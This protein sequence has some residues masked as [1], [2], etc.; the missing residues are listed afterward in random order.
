MFL[1]TVILS[2]LEPSMLVKEQSDVF[3]KCFLA[4]SAGSS[5]L[6]LFI[7]SIVEPVLTMERDF[8][9]ENSGHN[10]EFWQQLAVGVKI[11]CVSGFIA[12]HNSGVFSHIYEGENPF[13]I[14]K[15][16]QTAIFTKSLSG[17]RVLRMTLEKM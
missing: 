15:Y 2:S 11:M 7:S 17:N 4:I 10:S 16:I 5:W 13:P 1:D 14:Q 8:L 3:S 9:P 6:Y 12:H